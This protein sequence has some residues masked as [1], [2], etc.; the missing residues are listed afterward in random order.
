MRLRAF[1]GFP[2]TAGR[3]DVIVF[4][5]D[6]GPQV[7]TGYY[8]DPEK[9]AEV[10]DGD[11]WFDTGD[12]KLEQGGIQDLKVAIAYCESV[13]DY[14]TRELLE[15]ILESEEEHIDWI[16]TQIDLIEKVGVQNYIQSQ[17]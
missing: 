13:G 8:R 6:C 5:Q 3:C 10:L 16:E 11:G 14:G 17:I 9:S 4:D 2:T 12:L 15:D 1:D 7:F